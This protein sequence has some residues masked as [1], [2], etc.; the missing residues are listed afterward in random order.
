M[1]DMMRQI[2]AT[3]ASDRPRHENRAPIVSE[4]RQGYKLT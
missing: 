3:D 1:A 4:L 2:F